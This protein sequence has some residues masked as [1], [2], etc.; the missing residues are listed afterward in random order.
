MLRPDNEKF[1][2]SAVRNGDYADRGEA[3]DQA[4]DLLR[5]RDQ[6]VRDVNYGIEQIERGEV[7]DSQ[8]VYEELR[9]KAA[10]LREH[11]RSSDT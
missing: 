8:E 5:K 3:L 2:E 4:V 11:A 7:V 6:L 1:I 9:R 10:L